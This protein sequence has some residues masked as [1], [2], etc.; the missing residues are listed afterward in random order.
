[1]I[2]FC[3][4]LLACCLA[5]LDPTLAQDESSRLS[6]DTMQKFQELQADC[7]KLKLQPE[8][9][10]RNGRQQVADVAVFAKAVEWQLKHNEFPKQG[11]ARQAEEAIAIG[12]QRAKD[13][14]GGKA[15]WLNRTG[16]SIRG[17]VSAV[18]GSIQP[19]ALSLPEGVD[20]LSGKRWPLYVKLH[21]RADTM[22]ET[23]FISRHEGKPLPK[24]QTWIQLDVYGRGNN[25]YRWAGETDV[26]EAIKDVGRRFRIDSKRITVHGFSM[27]GAGAWHLGM[28]HPGKWSSM[29]AG[30][31][32]VD[33]YRY[34]KQ[35][36]QRPTWQHQNLTIYDT[37]NY[38]LNAANLPVVGYGG[39]NDSQLLTGKMMK[40]AAEKVGVDFKLLIGKGMG[41][42]FD[43]V[44]LKSFMDFHAA[45][46]KKGR[47]AS[48]SR[49]KIQFVTH[50]LKYN[51]CDWLTIQ[52]LD[53]VFAP[54]TITAE[55]ATDGT[56][57]IT[58]EN[59]LAFSVSRDIAQDITA[60]DSE[61]LPCIDAAEGLLPEVYYVKE[62][63]GWVEL[64]YEASLSFTSNPNR[65]KR[66][67]LQGPIDDAF[68]N[69]FVCVTPT[70]TARSKTHS[71]WANWTLNRFRTE[72]DKWMRAKL[73]EIKDADLSVEQLR[74]SN[75]I[76][77]GDPDSNS[78]L[79]SILAELPIQWEGK[80]ITVN[81][82]RY[83]MSKH[84]LSM[85]FPNPRNPK[86]YVVIN[87]GHT[88]HDKDFKAS[89]SWLF[90]RLG[91]IAIQK[92]E[93]TED[94]F[95]ESTVWASNFDS[96]WNLPKQK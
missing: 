38:A 20:P 33:F 8:L 96:R 84:G 61:K 19:Y 30:A 36:E 62:S 16:V 77:F 95:S 67:D 70:G 34:Q 10:N 17:Y 32:F 29:G 45:A 37:V 39:E 25:A 76:L 53:N 54:T 82:D 27:G 5:S 56:M 52:E 46:S 88:F 43:D 31:G 79:K 75:V 48:L 1:M 91:D 40:Q 14:A 87:S 64:D 51:K 50:T 7:A 59:V 89:N 23:N 13:L 83:D 42:K 41:H 35:S 55:R 68:M 60:D 85:I 78:V 92:F 73:P 86:R 11:Y 47:P 21:G 3:I 90:P 93:R 81:G 94:G 22:N 58:T 24:G 72:F 71:A 65:N 69:S 28:H 12:R 26:F 9:Q 57:K 80:V 2:R 6:E 66:H 44:S 74:D 15:D 4:A 63:G 49:D 18:D